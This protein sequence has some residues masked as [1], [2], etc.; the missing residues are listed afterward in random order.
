MQLPCDW[1]VA[2][3]ACPRVFCQTPSE[4][5]PAPPISS[6]YGNFCFQKIQDGNNHNAKLKA[7]NHWLTSWRVYAWSWPKWWIDSG[8]QA[9]SKRH[10]QSS[11][12]NVA[13]SF[14]S[15]Q[16]F[17]PGE[18]F[19]GVYNCTLKI[20]PLEVWLVNSFDYNCSS[21]LCASSYLNLCTWNVGRLRGLE[22][23]HLQ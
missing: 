13:G 19:E 17:L 10:F 5:S 9:D 1:E 15:I 12:A 18:Y 2:S 6:K 16:I 23:R 20:L 22:D 11:E 21:L 7:S 8:G 3:T 4:S 14:Y